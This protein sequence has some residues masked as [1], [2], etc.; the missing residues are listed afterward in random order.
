MLT[1]IVVEELTSRTNN[2]R[3][4]G[5]AYVYCIFQRQNEQKA[6]DLLASVLKQL[7]Q[8]QYPLPENVKSLYDG[9]KDRQPRPSFDQISST[10]QSVATSYSRI[11]IVIDALDECSDGCRAGL[12]SEI[13]KLQAKTGANIFATSRS[14]PN[15]SKE[16][17]GSAS[18]QIHA[19]EGDIMT[20]I[21][22][23]MSQLQPCVQDDSGLQEMVKSK[24]S[25]SVGGM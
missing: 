16:F 8:G 14:I 22:G 12:L 5:V 23:H 21:D 24:I 4:I 6:D 3:D 1:S 17:E 20:Y 10:L 18:L 2:N 11:F 13:F 19:N 15:I 7:A 9:Y 25:T